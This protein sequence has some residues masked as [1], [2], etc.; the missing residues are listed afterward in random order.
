MDKQH[1]LAHGQRWRYDP[2][3]RRQR[4]PRQ[5]S[6]PMEIIPNEIIMEIF[7]HMDEKNV[8]AFALTSKRINSIWQEKRRS[9]FIGMHNTQFHEF[10]SLFGYPYKRSNLQKAMLDLAESFLIGTAQLDDGRPI[11]PAG[12]LDSMVQEGP[13]ELALWWTHFRNIRYFRDYR[14]ADDLFHLC[15]LPDGERFDTSLTVKAI[16]LEYGMSITID[17]PAHISGREVEQLL[18]VFSEQPEAVRTRFLEIVCF[19]GNKI[20]PRETLT[21]YAAQLALSDEQGREIT[22]QWLL[23]RILAW[24]LHA[25]LSCSLSGCHDIWCLDNADES[26]FE[27]WDEDDFDRWGSGQRELKKDLRSLL[28]DDESSYTAGRAEYTFVQTAMI[29]CRQM[30]TTDPLI[31]IYRGP[32]FWNEDWEHEDLI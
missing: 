12:A 11:R 14:I 7:T 15:Y 27:G 13:D 1:R 9:I 2:Q 10:T 8:K 4:L 24:S 30:W 22:E 23:M 20:L 32:E 21:P 29:F 5:R 6:S 3:R 17:Y 19:L 31:Q 18:L 25:V 26:E 16:I 28:N